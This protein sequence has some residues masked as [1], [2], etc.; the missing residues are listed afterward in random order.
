MEAAAVAAA[1]I[2]PPRRRV[3]DIGVTAPFAA[4]V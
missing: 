3:T 2:S 1:A 4:D